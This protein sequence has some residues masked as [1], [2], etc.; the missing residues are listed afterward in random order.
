MTKMVT[1][2]YEGFSAELKIC[3]KLYITFGYLCWGERVHTV[4]FHSVPRA[5]CMWRDCFMNWTLDS[6]RLGAGWT[7][8]L[9]ATCL[10]LVKSQLNTK[11]KY[12]PRNQFTICFV[13]YLWNAI[14]VG[15]K[16]KLGMLWA[17]CNTFRR[18][19]AMRS[20]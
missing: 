14:F 17:E 8:T 11:E 6:R 10:N 9:L 20:T 18:S 19:N 1:D 4:F 2:I 5:I 15:R 3:V 7:A 13:L 12:C 16:T